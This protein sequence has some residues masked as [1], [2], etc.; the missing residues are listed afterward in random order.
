MQQVT[1][2]SF[3]FAGI[4][5]CAFALL[6]KMALSSNIWHNAVTGIWICQD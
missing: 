2:T 6:T 1:I 3:L 5:V 4:K